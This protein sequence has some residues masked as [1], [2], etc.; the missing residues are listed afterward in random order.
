MGWEAKKRERER[1]RKRQHRKQRE[2]VIRSSSAHTQTHSFT[3]IHH[4]Y[5]VYAGLHL[6]ILT[7]TNACTNSISAIHALRCI[8]TK[9]THLSPCILYIYIHLSHIM[10]TQAFSVMLTHILSHTHLHTCK[11][12]RALHTT[13]HA[14]SFHFILACIITHISASTLPY[15]HPK[16]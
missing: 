8:H 2:L 4:T 10:P 16:M 14:L 1:E 6:N 13:C 3:Y 9:H 7:H 15:T 5:F 11:R 12:A